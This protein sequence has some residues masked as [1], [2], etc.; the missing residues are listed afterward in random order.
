MRA[1]TILRSKDSRIHA[2]TRTL[3]GRQTWAEPFAHWP[4]PPELLRPLIPPALTLDTYDGFAWLGIV[5]F[6]M[7]DVYPRLVPSLPWLSAFPSSTSA[8]M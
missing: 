3:G 1:K 4:L 7:R 8:R 5:P 2:A 6:R